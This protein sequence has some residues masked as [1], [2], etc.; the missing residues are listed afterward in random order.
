[1]R[2]FANCSD[3][4]CGPQG[5]MPGCLRRSPILSG[6]T[7]RLRHLSGPRCEI[8]RAKWARFS[9]RSRRGGRQAPDR[10]HH[11]PWR[12]SHER[13]GDEGRRHRVFDE[14]VPGA[15][16]SGRRKCWARP[17]PCAP[18]NDEALSELQARF[19]VLTPRERAILIRVVE[20]RLNKQIAGDMGITETTVKVHRSNMMRKINATSIARTLPNGGQAE[21]A[22]G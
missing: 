20:G 22:A 9:A 6:P 12:H 2:S 14:A 16:F 19:E 10:L 5:C 17:R 7:R 15:G 4:F 8:T 1:M 13:A 11:R 21:A 18:R 3:D